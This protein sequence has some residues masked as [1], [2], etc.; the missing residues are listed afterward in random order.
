MR[1]LGT[2]NITP[3]LK[4][5]SSTDVM[6]EARAFGRQLAQEE[7]EVLIGLLEASSRSRPNSEAEPIA[8]A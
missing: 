6:R 2:P 5:R 4:Q 1:A 8:A 3:E 7:N